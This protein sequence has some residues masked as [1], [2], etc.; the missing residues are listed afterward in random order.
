MAGG[1]VRKT[2]VCGTRLAAGRGS[3]CG[4]P[5][6]RRASHDGQAREEVGAGSCAAHSSASAGQLGCAGH[7]GGVAAARPLPGGGQ[8]GAVL[9]PAPAVG[10]GRALGATPDRDGVVVSLV[11][12]VER[13]TGGGVDPR[14]DVRRRL[15][16]L[17]AALEPDEL[18]ERVR[19]A[20][21][22][23][24]SP[25][26]GRRSLRPSTRRWSRPRRLQ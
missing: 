13:V 2:I 16:G 3:A 4:T 15:G 7:H 26:D 24:A 18:E 6:A 17:E 8:R 5:T 9:V 25:L 11:G 19:A 22:G 12:V 23:Q 10:R 20:V 1:T 21:L 14:G